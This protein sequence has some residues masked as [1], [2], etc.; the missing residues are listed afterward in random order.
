MNSGKDSITR[1][2]QVTK[3]LGHLEESINA[4]DKVIEMN[5]TTLQPV[6]NS[7]VPE[8]EKVPKSEPYNT[9]MAIRLSE[10]E[11]RIR[12]CITRLHSLHNRIE[13]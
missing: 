8:N 4:L 5:Y 12:E 6:M 10:S 11:D 2:K 7:E 13:L 3:A 1:E 9:P